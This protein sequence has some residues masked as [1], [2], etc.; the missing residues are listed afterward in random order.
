MITNLNE[1]NDFLKK[2][3]TLEDVNN[4]DLPKVNEESENEED[5]DFET[6]NNELNK[7]LTIGRK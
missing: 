1:F 7:I 3:S 5:E 6:F 2:K 4:K